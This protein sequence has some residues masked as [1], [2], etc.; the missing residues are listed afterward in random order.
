MDVRFGLPGLGPPAPG[1]AVVATIGNFDGVH[2]GHRA[3]LAELR[4]RAEGAGALTLVCLFAPHPR[5]VL[6]PASTP[7]LL[8]TLD[9]RRRWL[10]PLG[11][12]RVQV[13]EFT[14][15]V[16]QLRAETFLDRLRG[17]HRLVGLVV[18][19]GFAIGH[20]R[21][22]TA[23]VLGAHGDAHGFW[24]AEVPPTADGGRR[25]SSTLVRERVAAGDMAGAARML[26][27]PFEL[28]GLVVPGDR[29]ATRLGFPTANL[30]CR[31]E[32]LLPAFGIYA[33]WARRAGGRWWPAVASIG[34]R[35]HFGGGP[36][37][38]EVHG[39]EP[40]G[41]LYGAR[42]EVRCLDRLRDE[43]RFVSDTALQAQIAADVEA[44]AAILARAARP[45]DPDG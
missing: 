19:P 2:L 15:R 39:L 33:V 1:P 24:V 4:R 35:P 8:T 18:G 42:L 34:V 25:I 13:V 44:A 16:S 28:T 31:P 41:D 22:G 23:E 29:V 10:Q 20:R 12:D 36:V 38:V 21:H 37:V 17:R 7:G 26:G 14:R 40:P 27:R 32:Q 3:L 30:R 6:A 11:V 9:A 45:A 43:A 5:A